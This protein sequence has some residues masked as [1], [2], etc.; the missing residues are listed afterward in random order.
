MAFPCV[1]FHSD[2]AETFGMKGKQND[3]IPI[4]SHLILYHLFAY[5]SHVFD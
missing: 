2:R 1:L 4:F 5:T 3:G